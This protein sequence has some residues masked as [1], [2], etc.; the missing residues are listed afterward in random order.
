M[1]SELWGI[2]ECLHVGKV[3]G[4]AYTQEFDSLMLLTDHVNEFGRYN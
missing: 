4:S 2:V 3:F 1:K